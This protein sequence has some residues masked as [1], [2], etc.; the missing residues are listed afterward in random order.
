MEIRKSGAAE[1]EHET[2]SAL[3]HK[4]AIEATLKKYPGSD[5]EIGQRLPRSEQQ[6]YVVPTGKLVTMPESPSGRTPE[7]TIHHELGHVCVGNHHGF[8]A[9]GMLSHNNADM[10]G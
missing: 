7:D 4:K 1:S 8:E 9:D 6:G 2:V 10:G 3:S 5:V